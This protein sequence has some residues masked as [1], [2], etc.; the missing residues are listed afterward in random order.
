[1]L[2]PR[3]VLEIYRLASKEEARPSLQYV[4]AERDRDTPRLTATDGYRL[5]TATW[6]EP[7]VKSG[8]EPADYGEF[9]PVAGFVGELR[10]ESCADMA[11]AIPHGEVPEVYRHAWLEEGNGN[12]L[13]RMG[14]GDKTLGQ[15]MQCESIEP[16][17][18]FPDWKPVV[19][20]V[21]GAV[22]IGVNAKL[23]AELLAVMSRVSGETGVVLYVPAD[24]TAPIGIHV[25]SADGTRHLDGL[26]MPMRLDL[27]GRPEWEDVP[28]LPGT[29]A[30]VEPPPK[31]AVPAEGEAAPPP[32]AHQGE[33]GLPGAAVKDA[34]D[35]S[36][37]ANGVPLH[38]R[39]DGASEIRIDTDRPCAKCGRTGATAETGICLECIGKRIVRGA[40]GLPAVS[41]EQLRIRRGG[42]GRA[43]RT[44]T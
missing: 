9:R 18:E 26:I 21:K 6:T 23:F 11:R 39:A 33:L 12:H 20:Q 28:T 40:E 3:G 15:A 34:V 25:D 44:K 4:H 36:L 17:M 43:G 2:I 42:R 22:K 24:P 31:E 7:E 16:E 29:P 1:M 41:G 19:D 38:H 8:E 13:I 37:E 14:A 27:T 32:D 30:P 5:L 10:A 35:R